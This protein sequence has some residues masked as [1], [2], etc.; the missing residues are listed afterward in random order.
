MLCSMGDQKAEKESK[1]Y[2]IFGFS[3]GNEKEQNKGKADDIHE[4]LE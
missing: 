3:K 1:R 2:Y 4:S